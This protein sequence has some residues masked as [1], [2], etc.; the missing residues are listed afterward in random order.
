MIEQDPH[1]HQETEGFTFTQDPGKDASDKFSITA[2]PGRLG[3]RV[4]LSRV[5]LVIILAGLVAVVLM[6]YAIWLAL[7]PVPDHTAEFRATSISLLT[8][9]MAPFSPVLSTTMPISGTL[10]ST[11]I[12]GP[13][14]SSTSAPTSTPTR[15]PQPARSGTPRSTGG[16]PTST[17][18]SSLLPA[19]ILLEPEDGVTPFDRTVFKWLWEGPP[20]EANQAFD[21]RIWS[22]QEEQRGTLKRGA[23]SPTQDTQAEVNL[24]YV[25]AFE[26]YGPG[27]YYWTVV[28]VEI[29]SDGSPAV[30]GDWG[31]KRRFVYGR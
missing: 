11:A 17:P 4:Q 29:G 23:I 15:Q 7:Q 27:D 13:S 25:P 8:A 30:I 6:G 19:P 10:S 31:E 5:R 24:R 12:P 9:T 16:K 18:I 1:G 14:P 26:D 28:V 3:S 20:L 22:A 2:L 21:L